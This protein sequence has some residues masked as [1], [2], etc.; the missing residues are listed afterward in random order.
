MLS[1]NIFG[2]LSLFVFL[3]ELIDNVIHHRID[4]VDEE[5]SYHD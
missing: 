3:L 2:R 4:A 5:Q 1:L